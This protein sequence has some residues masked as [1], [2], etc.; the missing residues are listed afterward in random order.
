MAVQAFGPNTW[1]AETDR[2]LGVPGQMSMPSISLSRSS[3]RK[4]AGLECQHWGHLRCCQLHHQITLESL[5]VLKA[6]VKTTGPDVFAL[7]KI[8]QIFIFLNFSERHRKCHEIGQLIHN[9]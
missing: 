3:G 2:C 1:E 6:E 7:S 9:L 8:E 4:R 5:L